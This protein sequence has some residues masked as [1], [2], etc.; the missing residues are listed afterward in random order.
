MNEGVCG[1][2]EGPERGGTGDENARQ[3][4][5]CRHST[6]ARQSGR[7]DLYQTEEFMTR[8]V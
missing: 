6:A 4:S 5:I 7:G 1:L 3:V 8:I 2:R